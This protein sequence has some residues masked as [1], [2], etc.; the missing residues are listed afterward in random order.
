MKN[1]VLAGICAAIGFPA[2]AQCDPF[3]YDWQE[4]P[5]GVSPNPA[6]GEQFSPATINLTYSETIYVKAPI[7]AADIDETLPEFVLIDSLRLNDVLV[8]VGGSF[9][10]L[11]NIGLNLTCNNQ[12]HSSNPCMFLPG[13]AYCGDISGTPNV[14]GQFP[15]K[16]NVTGYITFFGPQAVP[17]EFEGYTLVINGPVGVA[18]VIPAAQSLTVSQNTPNPAVDMTNIQFDLAVPGEV[19]IHVINLVGANIFSKKINGKKGS[20]TY[21]LDTSSFESGVYLYSVSAGDRKFTRRML[22]QH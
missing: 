18:E 21:R 9:V 16:I 22:V 12:G 15:V 11:S 2:I 6:M 8:D 13:N 3:A 19:E 10:P 14:S 17:Y 5:F 4:A 1:I 20:N 7:S